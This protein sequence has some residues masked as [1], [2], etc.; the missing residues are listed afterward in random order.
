MGKLIDD[1]FKALL[2]VL[3]LVAVICIV[4]ALLFP[5]SDG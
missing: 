2:A 4:Y 5:V 3:A 1:L